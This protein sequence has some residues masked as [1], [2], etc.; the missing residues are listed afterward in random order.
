MVSAPRKLTQIPATRYVT[1]KVTAAETAVRT[2]R[3]VREV[4]DER[5]LDDGI[6][7][8]LKDG[9]SWDGSGSIHYQTW[10]QLL[11]TLRQDVIKKDPV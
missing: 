4:S 8:Y 6:W 5:G 2:H 3:F 11:R 1:P 7:V 9:Y 10:S